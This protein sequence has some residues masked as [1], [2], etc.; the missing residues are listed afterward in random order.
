MNNIAKTV[1]GSFILGIGNIG[2]LFPLAF[3]VILAGRLLGPSNYGVF[4]LAVIIPNVIQSIIGFGVNT[5][6]VRFIQGELAVD[7]VTRAKQITL[8]GTLFLLISGVSAALVLFALQHQ[9]ADLLSRPTL[10]YLIGIGAF[11]LVGQALIQAVTSVSVGWLEMTIAAKVIVSQAIV[12]LVAVVSLIVLF[13]V[14]GGVIGVVIASIAG[15]VI[16]IFL[17]RHWFSKTIVNF[18]ADVKNLLGF[19]AFIFANSITYVIFTAVISFGLAAV[20]SN[21]IVGFYTAGMNIVIPI[22]LISGSIGSAVLPVIVKTHKTTGS[23]L[24]DTRQIMT[25]SA[26]T[27]LPLLAFTGAV[28]KQLL[29]AVYGEAYAAGGIYLLM[30]L[31]EYLPCAFGQS[32]LPSVLI[33]TDRPRLLIIPSLA[34]LSLIFLVPLMHV[35]GVFGVITDVIIYNAIYT[36]L[37]AVLI[38]PGVFDYQKILKVVAL[39]AFSAGMVFLLSDI[40]WV[41]GFGVGCVVY[42]SLL[43]IFKILTVDDIKTLKDGVDGFPVFGLVFTG[44]LKYEETVARLLSKPLY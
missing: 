11:A 37:C 40:S 17:I 3:E 35:F 38:G 43:P 8:N 14:F 13:V 27:I 10:A 15:G 30:L 36:G 33:G 2:S 26:I 4:A 16:G 31:L 22:S 25:Y 1:N 7:N 20:A 5:S 42:L 21:S 23:H 28:A 6:L 12:K 19:S 41:L 44:V 9:I 32:V 18:K 24:N 39:T 34:I 29:G